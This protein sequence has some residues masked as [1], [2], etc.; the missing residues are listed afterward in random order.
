MDH[1]AFWKAAK[2]PPDLNGWEL[3]WTWSFLASKAK[4]E[5]EPLP[6]SG[7]EEGRSPPTP[8]RGGHTALRGRSREQ[9]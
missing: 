7:T 5:Q 3:S 2:Q 8:P 1:Q 6:V 9:H 4:T